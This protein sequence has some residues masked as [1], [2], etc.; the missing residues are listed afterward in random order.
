LNEEQLIQGLKDRDEAAFRWLVEHYKDKIFNTVLNIVQDEDEADDCAQEVF[1]KVYESIG[2]FK[3][4]SSLGTWIYRIA[5]TKALDNLRRKKTRSKLQTLLPWW[6]PEE[7]KSNEN[8]FNHPGVLLENKERAAVLFN[9]VS[10]LPDKQR[11]AFTLIRIQ[12]M[13]YAEAC[14]I[15]GQ[16]VKA[17]ESLVSRAKE[18][19]E[20]QLIRIKKQ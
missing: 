2:G 5:V 4:E 13:T 15:M 16:G 8:S 9:A 11:I 12:G 14:E 7:K 19:L 20:K 6:M 18:N 1:I 10:S 3:G 17:V